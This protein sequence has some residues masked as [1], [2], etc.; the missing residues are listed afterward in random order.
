MIDQLISRSGWRIPLF[1]L[2][3]LFISC[4]KYLDKKPVKSLA[5]PDRLSDLQAL[6]DNHRVI[7]EVSP[8]LLDL[9][10][11]DYYVSTNYWQTYTL[12][13]QN[14]NYIWDPTVTQFNSWAQ[15]YKGPV[16]F[17]NVV[18]DQLP[19]ITI[20]GKE[21][22]T[23]NSIRGAALFHRAFAFHQIA[24]LYCRPYSSTATTDP[25]I[26]LR[27]TSAIGNDSKR[28]TVQE[29][30]GQVVKDLKEA[31]QF[32]PLQSLYPTR[33]TK[34]AAWGALARTYLSMRDYGNAGT[35]ADSCLQ[36]FDSLIDYNSLIP[37]GNPPIKR[38]NKETIFYNHPLSSG[39]FR[40]ANIDTSLY[41]SYTTDDLRK[42]VFFKT[43]PDGTFSFQGSYDGTFLPRASFDGIAIDEVYLIRAECFARNGNTTAAMRDLNTLLETRWRT[44]MFTRFTASDAA[45]ALRIILR[46]R[47]KE[48]LFRGLRWSDLRR[49]NEEGH[50]ITLTRIINNKTY[51]LPPNDPRWVMLIPLEVIR[52]SG[53]PQ[54]PR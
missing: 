39:M 15:P 13:F 32:L 35:Y 54:N 31:A 5:V 50:N 18:L 40:R 49:F 19:D 10:A 21:Q 2:L 37:V 45:D 47:R 6:L 43:N 36:K 17:S 38:F 8:P 52:L 9:V 33:P 51:Q 14:L 46:E 20:T 11:D 27:T 42:E 25:G 41:Q 34:V 7:N 48:L 24:Q 29:T 3:I 22:A 30:Y 23:Y 4:S 1:F 26:V 28:A 44:N 53:I 16:Y 12:E